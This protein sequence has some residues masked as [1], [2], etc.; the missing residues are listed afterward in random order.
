MDFF[1]VSALLHWIPMMGYVGVTTIL[2]LETGV[3][4]FFFLPGDSLLFISGLL[5]ARNVFDI[6]ILLPLLIVATIVGYLL[7]YWVG[8][9]LEHLL[10]K[11]PNCWW[12]KRQHVEKAQAFYSDHGAF[13]LITGRFIP[14]I[15]TFVPVVAGM[16]NMKTSQFVFYAVSGGIIWVSFLFFLGYWLGAIYPNILHFLAPIWL[17][18]IILSVIPLFYKVIKNRLRSK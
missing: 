11:W 17:S 15:R 14:I 4:V 12:Y 5:S 10:R 1:S 3:F 16:V 7:A 9:K 13:A 2:F 6:N 18:I 8:S